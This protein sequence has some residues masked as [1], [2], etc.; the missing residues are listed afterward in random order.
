MQSA[1]RQT[2]F[3]LTLL[4]F[5]SCS[6]TPTAVNQE[7]G[8]NS[9][10]SPAEVPT[11]VES[12]NEL[13]DKEF[14]TGWIKLFD[15]ETFFGWKPNSKLNW[16]IEDGVIV[17]DEGDPGLLVTTTKFAD[18]E[19]RCDYRLEEGGNSGIFLR[20][21][22]SPKNTAE[23]CYELNMCDSH[24]SFPTG[25]LVARQKGKPGIKADGKWNTWHV[26]VK[27]LTIHAMLNG[28]TVLNYTDKPVTAQKIGFIG[29]QYNGGKIE[30]RNV[31]LKP[32]RMQSLFNGEDLTGWKTIP[33]SRAEFTVEDSTIHAKGGPGFLQTEDAWQHFVLQV[34]ARTNADN[35]NSGI[36]FRSMPGTEKEPSNGYELQIHNGFAD[37]DRTRP[38]DYQTGFGT[39]AI[40]RRQKA[41][42]VVPNDR[43]W[44]TMTLVAHGTHFSTWVNGYQVTDWTDDR[45]P[46]ENPRRGLRREA[47]HFILQAHD[48]TTDVSFRN[49]RVV[50][51]PK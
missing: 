28:E 33:G 48:E 46:H 1:T 11:A 18:Y 43:E 8:N 5:V 47:G 26:T 7:S 21:V 12:H 10:S 17:A 20:T 14:A 30:F 29:L 25:S 22:F 24:E 45:E 37:G 36:F 51:L 49:L 32:L 16:R 39:G 27:G 38:N 31:F 50:K 6:E 4:F 44:F 19:L 35:V 42:R 34:D 9:S 3:F 23:D 41:R 13:T 15:S 2:L 40:F